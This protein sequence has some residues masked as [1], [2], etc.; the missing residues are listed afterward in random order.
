MGPGPPI[1]LGWSVNLKYIFGTEVYARCG[2][3]LLKLILQ[4]LIQ[5][6]NFFIIYIYG[7]VHL[8]L[9]SVNVYQIRRNFVHRVLKTRMGKKNWMT[10][11]FEEK[12]LV[13]KSCKVEFSVNENPVQT[14]AHFEKALLQAAS[15]TR[16][17]FNVGAPK[18]TYLGVTKHDTVTKLIIFLIDIKKLK[19]ISAPQLFAHCACLYTC[20]FIYKLA[21]TLSAQHTGTERKASE[22]QAYS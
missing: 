14:Q 12:K 13:A 7:R 5:L 3:M 11:I 20:F 8:N 4:C 6:L 10:I 22:A 16:Q 15:C 2:F 1:V 18:V 21:R 19:C 9:I 17:L